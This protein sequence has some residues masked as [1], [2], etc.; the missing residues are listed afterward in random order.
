MRTPG[1]N[2]KARFIGVPLS[3]LNEIFGP[4]AI[5]YIS[6][7][8]HGAQFGVNRDT[9]PRVKSVLLGENS[10]PAAPV[11]AAVP[12]PVVSTEVTIPAR[13]SEKVEVAEV[14][15]SEF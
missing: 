6:I 1:A 3:K 4:N 15:L 7:E 12:A 11:V 8:H 13:P 5:V 9:L 14:D 10:V 2:G